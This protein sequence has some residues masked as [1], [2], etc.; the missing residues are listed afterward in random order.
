ML[1]HDLILSW[2]ASALIPHWGPT[3]GVCPSHWA[4]AIPCRHWVRSKTNA[5][6]IK[7][8]VPLQE[9]VDFRL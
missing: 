4:V 2:G 1:V 8:G 3:L 5:E 7:S 6:R 9:A